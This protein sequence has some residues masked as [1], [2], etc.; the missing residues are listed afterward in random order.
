MPIHP[1]TT[2][3]TC[4]KCR[5]EIYGPN[6]QVSHHCHG[7][8]FALCCKAQEVGK[9]PSLA[10]WI[11]MRCSLDDEIREEYKGYICESLTDLMKRKERLEMICKDCKKWIEDY[12]RKVQEEAATGQGGHAEAEGHAQGGGHAEAEM[13]CKDCKEEAAKRNE[14]MQKVK[15][16]MNNM[17]RRVARSYERSRGDAE[18]EERPRTWGSLDL[19]L[20]P[21]N[22]S[23]SGLPP[24]PPPGLLPNTSCDGDFHASFDIVNHERGFEFPNGR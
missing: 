13:I 11:C 18:A 10:E 4:D 17:K 20:S 8:H 22:T 21:R 2:V 23:C 12:V 19:Y 5:E 16:D 7:K 6:R 24:P 15:D 9:K 14:D 1:L 3:V